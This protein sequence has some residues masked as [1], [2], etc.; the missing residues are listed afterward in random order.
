MY[1]SLWV[2]KTRSSCGVSRRNESDRRESLFFL[3]GEA[4]SAGPECPPGQWC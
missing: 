4:T 2:M 1:A 3:K